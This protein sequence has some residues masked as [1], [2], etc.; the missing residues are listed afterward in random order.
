M[1]TDYLPKVLVAL[2]GWCENMM[3]E[4]PMVASSLGFSSTEI[5]GF[6]GDLNWVMYDC[7]SSEDAQTNG[8]AWVQFRKTHFYGDSGS[9][10]GT[11]PGTTAPTP[12]SG[13][14]RPNGLIPR[15]R[16]VVGRIKMAPGYTPTIGQTLRIIPAQI[17]EDD[18]SA[19]PDTRGKALPMFKA[20]L[21]CKR[22]QFD[23]VRTRC[24]RDGD[25][26]WT[27]LGL[28]VGTTLVDQRPPSEADKPEVRTYEQIY[29]RNNQP[30]G[31]W[32]DSVRVTLQP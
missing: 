7:K 1:Q 23:A 26:A 18:S 15:I 3:L 6:L 5:L 29:V 13:A 21:R 17:V 4:F 31:H 25:A 9:V 2:T 11:P 30:V 19:K 14:P 28:S 20:E 10:V 22:G 16:G 24:K 27:D 32:S 12:P 8:A